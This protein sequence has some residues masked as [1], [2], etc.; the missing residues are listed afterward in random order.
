[1]FLAG[2]A[3][4]PPG[5]AAAPGAEPATASRLQPGLRLGP[6]AL[7]G[8]LGAGGMAEV[9]T[10]ARA[11]GAWEGEAAVKLLKPA[12]ASGLVLSRFAQE[13]Q[14]LARLSHPH[15]ARL[16]DAGHTPWG[17]PFFVMEKVRGQPLDQ[18]CRELPLERR[19]ELFLQLADAVAYAHRNLLVHR[20]LK[21]SNVMV[22]EQGQ[23]K[24]L[25]F[26]IAKALDPLEPAQA[27]D[28]ALTHTGARPFTPLYASPEQVRGEPVSTATDLYSLGVLLYVLL[29]GLRP[30]GRH[31]TTPL[32]AARSVLEEEPTRPS[33]LSPA[34][35]ADPHWLQHRRRLRGDLDNILLKA[36]EKAPD[37][38]Y[39]TVEAMARDVRAF[40]AHEPVSAHAPSWSYRA[41]KFI[42]RN[43][44]ASLASA[45]AA[46][47]L[48]VGSVVSVWQAREAQAQRDEA[49]RHFT[50]VRQ[51]ARQLVFKY[52]DQIEHLPGATAAR[53]ALLQDAVTFLDGLQEAAATDPALARELAETYY[54][55]SRLQG[56]NGTIHTGQYTAARR[57]I[58]RAVQTS[59]LYLQAPGV[60]VADMA[61][62]LNMRTT[63]VEVLQREGRLH[64]AQSVLEQAR[65]LL[66][67]LL[68]RAPRDTWSLSSAVSFHL[69]AARLA[70]TQHDVAHQ[71]D[72]L[73]ACGHAQQAWEAA[74][75]TERADPVNVY[76]PDTQAFA[77]RE[78]GQCRLMQ[79]DPAGAQALFE[80]ELRLRAF[81]VDKFPQDAD[82][83]YQQAVAL[84]L[85]ARS[86]LAQARPEAALAPQ[87]QAL[88]RLERARARDVG[89]QAATGLRQ[90]L[91]LQTAELQLAAGQ[92]DAAARA[93]ARWWEGAALPAVP[94]QQLPFA[95]RLSRASG[96]VLAA[97]VALAAPGPV[98]RLAPV[99][100][101]MQE[102]Q[103][104]LAVEEGAAG[105]ATQRAWL[106]LAQAA[107]AQARRRLG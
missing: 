58:E 29:T 107:Q 22:D 33:A 93:M 32:Q 77:L 72:W 76:L 60:T 23:V 81:M 21:P 73:Q 63:L 20:D 1:G 91:L 17:Q 18:V 53:E 41:G 102:A 24:L 94:P 13:Q 52:H 43:R 48:V 87:G 86:L 99:E 97:R 26:G 7:V 98:A 84:A 31:A 95:Q 37:R 71:G 9:W 92:H 79:D 103:R 8:P 40:L 4:L 10:V 5:A 105:H 2:P 55:I 69:V 50:Q 39:A 104:L 64:S 67:R 35:V 14:A 75:A 30:Y 34:E 3:V 78:R 46:L 44:A 80:Q 65:P 16:L 96:L 19:L 49:R 12:L 28:G 25:D 61:V 106:A 38:R 42:A 36:L 54:R 68:A 100:G 62:A 59:L 74:L 45:V 88:D 15:I 85:L 56:G 83:Q 90:R 66:E 47:A 11:D 70:G 51:L 27:Q 89:N 82:F 101:W 57:N 6:W